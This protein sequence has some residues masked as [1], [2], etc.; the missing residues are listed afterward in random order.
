MNKKTIIHLSGYLLCF[1]LSL[2]VCTVLNGENSPVQIIPPSKE[3]DAKEEDVFAGVTFTGG[4]DSSA[5]TLSP[6]TTSPNEKTEVPPKDGLE[7]TEDCT[8]VPTSPYP[9]STPAESPETTA[10]PT[11]SWQDEII[12]LYRHETGEYVSLPFEEYIT[13]VLSAEM[14]RHAGTEALKAQA[15]AARSYYYYRCTD[16]HP[17][18]PESGV[19][20]DPNHC[21]AY[22]SK[23]EI[24]SIFG[25]EKGEMVWSEYHAAVVL[26]R[27]EYLTYN[28]EYVAAMFHS[29]SDG[30]TESYVNYFGKDRHAYL[31]S[32]PTP[33]TA[34]ENQKVFSL[35]DIISLL[36]A[37]QTII[38]PSKP[39]GEVTRY[40]DS[41]R[42]KSVTMFGVSFGGTDIRERL[43]LA[44]TDFTVTFDNGQ[45]IFK[46]V[47]KGHGIG[48]SQRGAMLFAERGEDHVYILG[49]YFPG[50]TIEKER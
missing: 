19:C 49:H 46:T 1:I 47:G 7:D 4:I 42:V 22:N 5:N 48:L 21:M 16:K 32:V 8:V 14:S 18:H 30:N 41:G 11:A 33:E 29:S 36:L 6:E 3:T 44:S 12:T 24:C 13:G 43:D 23:E 38:D 50:C 15:V 26:C 45:Y 9:T 37:N 10:P 39:L 27:G 40:E 34:E 25:D 31:V 17:S 28:G 20:D 35:L 2:I